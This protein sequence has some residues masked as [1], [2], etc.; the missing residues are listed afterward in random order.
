MA[1]EQRVKRTLTEE[2]KKRKGESERARSRRTRLNSSL[3][4][5]DDSILKIS[6]RLRKGTKTNHESRAVSPL[7]V[8]TFITQAVLK[9][10]LL[11]SFTAQSA[12]VSAQ[13]RS[14]NSDTHNFSP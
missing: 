10:A 1:E 2:A 5:N 6:G 13:N 3:Q 12:A 8:K 9:T 7:T 14:N 11:P 4:L